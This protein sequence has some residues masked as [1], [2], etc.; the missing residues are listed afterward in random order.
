[1]RAR[2]RAELSKGDSSR[3]DIKQDA[4][5]IADLEFLVDYWVL[6]HAGDWP[7]LVTYTDNVRQLEALERVGLVPARLAQ[8]LTEAYLSFRRRLHG[9]ALANAGRVIDGSEFAAERALVSQTWQ[10]T[11]G[12]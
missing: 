9:L 6:K 10:R 5:G 7:E 2:M 3:F 11:F 1:M 4:G 12:D 8:H